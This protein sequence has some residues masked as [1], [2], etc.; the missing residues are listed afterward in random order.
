MHTQVF[1]SIF[2]DDAQRE[3]GDGNGHIVRMEGG[4][5]SPT[6]CA[7]LELTSHRFWLHLQCHLMLPETP[8]STAKIVLTTE[9]HTELRSRL[10]SATL[11]QREGRRARVIPLASQGCT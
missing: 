10:L 8:V 1:F 6:R 4:G 11:S 9:E 3:V 7:V 5:E 2:Y